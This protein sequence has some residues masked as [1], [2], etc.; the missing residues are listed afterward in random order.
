MIRDN[1]CKT[2]DNHSIN[3]THYRTQLPA[4]F[5]HEIFSAPLSFAVLRDFL[6]RRQTHPTGESKMKPLDLQTGFI[7]MTPP[8]CISSYSPMFWGGNDWCLSF[9]LPY[10]KQFLHLFPLFPCALLSGVEFVD[11]LGL[12]YPQCWFCLAFPQQLLMPFSMSVTILDASE[13]TGWEDSLSAL[14]RS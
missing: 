13:K 8:K 11:I 6:N 12:S 14:Q 10:S 7:F 5:I 3:A 1:A 9:S 2:H 4:A